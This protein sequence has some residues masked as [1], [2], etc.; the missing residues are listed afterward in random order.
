MQTAGNIC[1]YLYFHNE[2]IDDNKDK[3]FF[4]SYILNVTNLGV[5]MGH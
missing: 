4:Y 2:N 3:F 5:G 1:E